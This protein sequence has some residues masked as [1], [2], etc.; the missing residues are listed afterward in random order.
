MLETAN[1]L[2]AGF[3]SF[4]LYS[5][6]TRRASP[7]LE[8]LAARLVVVVAA[9]VACVVRAPSLSRQRVDSSKLSNTL[10]PGQFQDI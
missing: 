8:T 5:Q 9:V 6:P 3:L 4:S 2:L 7:R 10:D 1:L